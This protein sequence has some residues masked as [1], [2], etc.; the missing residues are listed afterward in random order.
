LKAHTVRQ[1][2]QRLS[3]AMLLIWL[4]P[5]LGLQVLPREM[6][7][8]FL[9]RAPEI[10]VILKGIIPFMFIGL[11]L[12]VVILYSIARG[13]FKRDELIADL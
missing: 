8:Q 10:E 2:Y 9:S 3:I 11:L 4:I 7:N 6:L 5:F 1:A 13:R 12:L